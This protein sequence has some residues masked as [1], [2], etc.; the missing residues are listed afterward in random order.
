MQGKGRVLACLGSRLNPY[1]PAHKT[2]SISGCWVH[3]KI[4]ATFESIWLYSDFFKF[5][6]QIVLLWIKNVENGCLLWWEV[7]RNS[8][9]EVKSR[10]VMRRW[11]WKLAEAP[12]WRWPPGGATE[13]PWAGWGGA[14][15]SP[16]RRTLGVATATS[17]FFVPKRASPSLQVSRRKEEGPGLRWGSQEEGW[18][19]I[20]F[21]HKSNYKTEFLGISFMTCV[22][23]GKELSWGP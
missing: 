18:L 5:I 13:S 19:Q 8:S 1:S 10:G 7:S 22:K 17:K 14:N 4:A 12:P 2:P 15:L 23:K 21:P 3:E 6:Y 16:G 11:N 20:Y 9:R